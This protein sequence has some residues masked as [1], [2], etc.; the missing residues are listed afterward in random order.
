MKK[1]IALCIF[2]PAFA[3]LAKDTKELIEDLKST[4]DKVASDA[5]QQL[6]S[7]GSKDAIEPLGELIKSNR[8]VGVRIV[9]TSALGR[10][11]QKGRSTTILREAI[12]TDP[13]NRMVYTQLLAIL[14]IKD[15][16]NPDL[17]KAVEFCEAN[18]KSDIY[19][20]D[21]VSRIRKIV[22]K[23]ANAPAPAADNKP[24]TP[25]SDAAAQPAAPK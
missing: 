23:G 12:E 19:I 25:A 9:A 16:D 5:A 6:G 17:L 14:N 10:I 18:K 3:L 20:T 8:A 11:D 2:M 15:T 13:D 1:L 22:P 21:I 7:D 4:D 24:Q